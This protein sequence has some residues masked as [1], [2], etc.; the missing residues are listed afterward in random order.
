[1]PSRSLLLV[2]LVGYLFPSPHPN[3]NPNPIPTPT[4]TPTRTPTP[5]ALP[6]APPLPPGQVG[7]LFP[8]LVFEACGRPKGR[9]PSP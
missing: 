8:M 1:M 7:Y 2:L 5:V 6:L 9:K 4:P 3:P